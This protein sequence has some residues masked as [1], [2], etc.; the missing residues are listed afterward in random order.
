MKRFLMSVALVAAVAAGYMMA[1]SDKS[2]VNMSGLTQAN[3]EA[4]AENPEGDGV[5]KIPGCKFNLLYICETS[6]DD[7]KLYKNRDENPN[8]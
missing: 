5:N 4:L 3:V 2:E 6:H 8:Q 1:G 7:Y